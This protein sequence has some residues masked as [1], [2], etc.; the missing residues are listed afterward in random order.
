MRLLYV[1][2][3]T[4]QY[5]FMAVFRVLPFLIML[6]TTD[7]AI[8]REEWCW[9]ALVEIYDASK[10]SNVIALLFKGWSPIYVHGKNHKSPPGHGQIRYKH[11]EY[12]AI[13]YMVCPGVKLKT[14][15]CAPH[16]NLR[17]RGREGGYREAKWMGVHT[18]T[19][20]HK[21]KKKTGW[22]V[23]R[24]WISELQWTALNPG[25]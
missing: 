13:V 17:K 25:Q 22:I 21:K 1:I 24:L 8:R 4:L 18:Y 20:T 10:W 23:Q 5:A 6:Q 11:E 9:Y 19:H 12:G 2:R 15:V 7:C 3:M 16:I 14:L